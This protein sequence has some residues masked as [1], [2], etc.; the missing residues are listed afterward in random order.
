MLE[1][2]ADTYLSEIWSGLP[3]PHLILPI[4]GDRRLEESHAANKSLSEGYRYNLMR[5]SL[6]DTSLCERS[7]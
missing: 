1:A 6:D 5:L 4:C 7:T 2:L 3:L